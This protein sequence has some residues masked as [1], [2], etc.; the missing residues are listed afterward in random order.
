MKRKPLLLFAFPFLILAV[1]AGERMATL[2]LGTYPASPTAW[3]LWLELRPLSAMFWQQVDVY[4]GGS[5]ALDAAI[6]A[7]ASIACWI[8]CHAKRSAFFFLA[9][10]I[11][12]IFAGLMIAV[13]SHSETASTIAAFTSPGGFPFTLTV[14]FTLKNSLVLL[15]GI[16]ACSYCHIAFLTEARERSVRAIRIL[17]LQ[18]DL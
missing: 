4:L 14:D 12:L 16:V 6:L 2:L 17:A 7:A 11:A 18:R 1:L 9:N 3:W 13:G 15:L 8:A 5:M 10:H